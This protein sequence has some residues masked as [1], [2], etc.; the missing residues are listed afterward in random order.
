MRFYFTS[1]CAAFRQLQSD[2]SYLPVRYLQVSIP[3]VKVNAAQVYILG[4]DPET[5]RI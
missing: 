4:R 3:T 2:K 5:Y 1:K